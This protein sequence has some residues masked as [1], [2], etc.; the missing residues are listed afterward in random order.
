MTVDPTLP[1]FLKSNENNI[2]APKGTFEPKV[3]E[4]TGRRINFITR[5]FVFLLFSR[6]IK[7]NNLRWTRQ[8][9][10]ERKTY[11]RNLKR[12]DDMLHVR[13]RRE[14]SIKNGREDISKI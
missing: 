2:R 5:S 10:I 3:E 14:N 11:L 9:S 4:V 1:I 7:S 13:G 8:M 6:F 12:R